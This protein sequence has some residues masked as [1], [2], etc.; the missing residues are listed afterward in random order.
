[1]KILHHDSEFSQIHDSQ[2]PLISDQFFLIPNIFTF[3]QNKNNHTLSFSFKLL[4]KYPQTYLHLPLY[5]WIIAVEEM[6]QNK[7]L[8]NRGLRIVKGDGN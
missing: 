3:S 5:C 7:I 8:I 4:L 6:K 2:N 1:M